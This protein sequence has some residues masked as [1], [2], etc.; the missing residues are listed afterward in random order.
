MKFDTLVIGAGWSGLTAATHLAAAG[1]RVCVVE[2]SR[3]P[4]GRS[5]TRRNGKD[6]YDHGAQYFT[7]RT[8]AFGRQVQQ[9]RDD[10]WIEKWTPRLTAIGGD[11]GHRDPESVQ[12]F[13]A[14]PG[15]NGVCRQLADALDCRFEA[16]VQA[17]DHDSHW[18]ATLA[19]GDT[20]DASRLL[21][22]APPAQAAALLGDGH[23]LSAEL[24]GVEF[25]P[26]IALMA[27]FERPLD[28]R[29]DA[30]F[31]NESG[32]LNWLARNSSKPGRTGECWV[33][34]ATGEWSR[35]HLDEDFDALADALAP[36]L[37]EHLGVDLAR[38]RSRMA[39][40]WRY[41]QA[42]E[43]REAGFLACD[44]QNLAVAGDWL[45]GSR[46]EGAWRSGRKAAEWLAETG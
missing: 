36:A 34:H 18:T 46:V 14:M 7:A 2:K 28:T 25:D 17:L 23:P 45:A 24:S 39:H 16:W 15:M 21:I 20:I 43:P 26:C 41:A 4:G 29:F 3:G 11:G 27:A 38:L 13:V 32:P 40:R 35:A 6:R 30:A 37:C 31:V 9:W 33:A 8:A 12:R 44:E 22:T 1:Q 10:G 5:A 19:D 42:V